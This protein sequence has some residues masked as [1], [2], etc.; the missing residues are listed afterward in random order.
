MGLRALDDNVGDGGFVKI[1]EACFCRDSE[2]RHRCIDRT[3]AVFPDGAQGR[4]GASIF[5][6]G[7]SRVDFLRI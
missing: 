3:P 6:R 7:F 1:G 5:R 2:L 4:I